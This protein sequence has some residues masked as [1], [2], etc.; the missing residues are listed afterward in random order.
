MLREL[1]M[2]FKKAKLLSED[3]DMRFLYYFSDTL[4]STEQT[5]ML[6][7]DLALSEVILLQYAV[8]RELLRLGLAD[9]K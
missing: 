5:E 6:S 8:T 3:M 1:M 4:L 9:E 2:Q 7:K